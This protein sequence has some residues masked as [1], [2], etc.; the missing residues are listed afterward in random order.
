MCSL[1][2]TVN[3]MR[4]EIAR[5]LRRKVPFTK[6]GCKL[7]VLEIKMKSWWRVKKSS[8]F[9]S[10]CPNKNQRYSFEQRKNQWHL[11]PLFIDIINFFARKNDF[12]LK[13][14]FRTKQISRKLDK[15]RLVG[16]FFR[17]EIHDELCSGSPA[18]WRNF[19]CSS[20]YCW[21]SKKKVK[22]CK[23]SCV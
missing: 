23:K 8:P 5:R 3:E 12:E 22:L 10:T 11:N 16:L 4:K 6:V 7:Y 19:L 9:V 2:A 18:R 21:W 1:I 13:S 17:G 14:F 15:E 20:L